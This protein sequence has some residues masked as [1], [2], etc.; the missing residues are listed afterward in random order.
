M[1]GDGRSMIK[2]MNTGN[3]PCQGHFTD[4]MLEKALSATVYRK[5]QEAVARDVVKEAHIELCTCF[6]CQLK[7]ELAEEG[8]N[9]M[10]CPSCHK[11]TCRLVI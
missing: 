7:V 3:P 1:F 8:G 6:N 10:H 4:A 11:E 2:C 5:F 9:I